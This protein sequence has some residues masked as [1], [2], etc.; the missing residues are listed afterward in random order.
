MFGDIEYAVLDVETTGLLPSHHDRI[1]EIGIVRTDGNGNVIRDYCTLVNPKRDIGPTHIHGIMAGDVKDAPL[2][3]EVIGD[4]FEAIKGAVVVAHNARFDLRFLT[5]ECAGC[6]TPLPALMSLCT[7]QMSR[8]L[9][10]GTDS[11]KLADIC[12]EL[13]IV[14]EHSH[15]ALGDARATASL[16]SRCLQQLKR[17]NGSPQGADVGLR[18]VMTNPTDWPLVPP[19]GKEYRR[20]DSML[21]R[22][23]KRGRLNRLFEKLPAHNDTNYAVDGYLNVLELAIEDRHISEGE[24][25]ALQDMAESL[26]MDRKEVEGVHRLFLRDLIRTAWLD[27]VITE[28]EQRDIET[29]ADLL[30]IPASEYE[31]MVAEEKTAEAPS[32]NITD[33]AK[34][35]VEGKEI[36]FTGAFNSILDGERVTREMMEK[37][38]TSKGMVVK[39]GVTKSLNYLVCAD[40][41]TMSGKAKKAR[42]YGIRII[43]EPAFFKMI[44]V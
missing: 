30:G 13:G 34:E 3:S 5:H 17:L 24:V 18:G 42:E 37:L 2:F 19:S 28:A 29:I 23:R 7:L 26:D 22:K 36:C 33:S 41:D 10:V 27:D 44:D 6:G 38:A 21:A 15:S 9:G 4:V 40:P 25:L 8:A 16:L 12:D 31:K 11:R 43:A 39:K 1:I 20:S 14:H 32:V 35:D